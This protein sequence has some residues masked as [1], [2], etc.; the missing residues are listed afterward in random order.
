MKPIVCASSFT[1]RTKSRST[2]LHRTFWSAAEPDKDA[3]ALAKREIALAEAERAHPS[4]SPAQKAADAIARSSGPVVV[5]IQI[6]APICSKKPGEQGVA[7]FPVPA[8]GKGQ[9][10]LAFK[11]ECKAPGK[12]LGFSWRGRKDGTNLVCDVKLL[13]GVKG[14]WVQYDALV[15]VG[16]DRQ[17]DTKPPVSTSGWERSTACVQSNAPQ[18]K[19]IEKKLCSPN[20]TVESYARKV[21]AF[22]RDDM[23]KGAP[24]KALDALAALQCGGSCTN[25]A[26]LSAALLRAHGIPARTVAHMPTWCSSKLYEHWLTEYWQPG[27]GWV[28]IDS[29][30]GRW[31]PDR[32]SR[33]VLAVSNPADEDLAFDP[34]HERFVMP[35]AA[36]LSVLEL[37][38]TLYP[39]DLTDDDA[40]NSVDQVAQLRISGSEEAA[41]FEAGS[42]SFKELLPRLGNRTEDET[43]Y[44]RVMAAA[45]RCSPSALLNATGVSPEHRLHRPTSH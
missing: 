14:S 33:V 15:L 35:G 25:K 42:R 1:I 16:G 19:A 2:F 40:I 20:D 11:I 22:V 36:Y 5:H 44:R 21:F 10:P 43:R 28:A 37:N 12:L 27:T 23:G 29:A 4:A 32:R 38:P 3:I 24:F 45:K 18:I 41:L 17:R 13:P 34:L 6:R 8:L 26:N 39:A 30:L 9:V 31:D 7:T